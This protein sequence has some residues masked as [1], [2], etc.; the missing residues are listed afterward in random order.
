MDVEV[1]HNCPQFTHRFSTSFPQV[2]HTRLLTTTGE[3]V[4][5]GPAG[6]AGIRGGIDGH[7]RPYPLCV[8]V[9]V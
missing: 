1:L 9:I 3:F 6:N 7:L 2:I 4:R 5:S 8:G